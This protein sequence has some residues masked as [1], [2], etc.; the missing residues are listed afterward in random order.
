MTFLAIMAGAVFLESRKQ[1]I[2]KNKDI[3]ETNQENRQ[4]T[5][6]NWHI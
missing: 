4:S 1:L 5:D 2:P 3:K 6:T